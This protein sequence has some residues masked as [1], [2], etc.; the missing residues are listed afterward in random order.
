MRAATCIL[1][2]LLACGDKDDDTGD[3]AA[4]GTDGGVATDGGSATDGGTEEEPED[5][6]PLG[7]AVA[8]FALEDLNPSS[9]TYGQL[10]SSQDL[11]GV[12]Y[13]LIFLDSRCKACGEVADAM[14]EAGQEHP[15][16]AEGLPTYAVNSYGAVNGNPDSI[17]GVVD[18]NSLPYLADTEATWLWGAY[19]ALNHDFFIVAADGT[20][21]VWMPLYVWPDD[22]VEYTDYMTAR[23]GE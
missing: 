15:S 13:A 23:F 18:G 22:L 11:V 3:G 14:W 1:L 7:V 19:G 17:E 10:V 4:A 12:P 5:P 8:D 2:V 21:E 9:A 16:W 6:H 20:L